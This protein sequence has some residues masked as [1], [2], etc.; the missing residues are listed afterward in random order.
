MIKDKN[1][2]KTFFRLM[3]ALMCQQAVV[4]SVNLIDN[5]MLG[6]YS[7][8]ALS[9]VAAVNMIQFIL[10]QL[11]YG[12]GN[13]MA[14]FISQYYA[15]RELLSIKKITAIALR[16]CVILSFIIFI[17]V[18][19]FPNEI[20]SIFSEDELIVTEGTSYMMIV[21]FTY[22]IFAITT[23]FLSLMRAVEKVSISLVVSLISLGINSLI[24]YLLI[25][26]NCGMPRLG[27]EGAAIGT[28]I[29][30]IVE[31]II[32]LFYI[33]KKDKIIS[34]KFRDLFLRD[35]LLLKDYYKAGFPMILGGILWGLNNSLQTIL[36]GHLSSNAIA[37]YSISST[38]FLFLKVAT[39]GAASA[40]QVMIAKAVGTDDIGMVKAYTR[41]MQ[42]L[43]LIIGAILFSIMYF[44]RF[45]LLS[46]YRLSAGTTSLAISFI[47]IESV[48]LG[49]NT[50]HMCMNNG[51][52]I[53]G[54]NTKYMT[55][56]DIVFIWFIALPAS[57]IAAFKFNA[58]PVIILILLNL[59]QPLKCIPAVFYG[60]SYK[61]IHKLAR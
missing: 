35:P 36:M 29:A 18:S 45:L 22:V 21:R 52:I 12:A 32:V 26:G 19:L 16:L 44:S 1:F 13:A 34:L 2:Y 38:E 53:G 37:A 6:N 59:D 43:Y 9:G 48:I 20:L 57:F 60:N 56:L 3:I 14:V 15:K 25:F 47:V 7:E 58:D 55:I 30:R 5:V 10:Q 27:V 31:F 17:I 11:V 39:V 40:S 42:V 50:Y 54:G 41:T 23:V 28:L 24:N 4:L 8:S 61:W 51:I 49:T 46:M 33:F